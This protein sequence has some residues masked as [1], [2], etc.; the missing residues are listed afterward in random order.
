M[1]KAAL[2][3]AIADKVGA[4]RKESEEMVN[5]FVRIVITELQKGETVN[6]A[7]FGQF[8]A[9]TRAGRIGVNPQNPTQKIQIPPVTVPKFKAGKALKDAL[10]GKKNL[11]PEPQ[12]PVEPTM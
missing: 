9:K 10:K 2:A 7:G 1:N 6:I 4:S 5:A 11:P 3:Q 12:Q 8:S